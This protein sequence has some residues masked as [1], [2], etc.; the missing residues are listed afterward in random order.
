MGLDKIFLEES[1]RAMSDQELLS[2][3]STDY[4]DLMPEAQEILKA[5]ITSRGIG[6][7]VDTAIELQVKGLSSETIMRYV[8]LVRSMPCPHCASTNEKL[9]AIIV[10]NGRYEDYVFGCPSC[11]QKEI[12]D[13]EARSIGAGLVTGF[14]GFAKATKQLSAYSTYLKQI[15]SGIPSDPLIHF[16]NKRIGEV[17]LYKHE[18]EKLLN[19]LRYPNATSF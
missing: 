1:Y 16:L 7:G 9:N 13:S 18:Y 14:D 12:S 10:A 19:L 4:K 3:I 15:K 17:E 5:E 6:K 8:D 2:I 11:L